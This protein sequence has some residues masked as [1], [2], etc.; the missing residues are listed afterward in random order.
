MPTTSLGKATNSPAIAFSKP[1][2]RAIPSP[3]LITEPDSSMLTE[4][5]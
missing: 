4:D 5:L 1:E 3:T 2:I